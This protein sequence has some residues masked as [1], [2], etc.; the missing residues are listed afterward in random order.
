MIW[1][2]GSPITRMRPIGPCVADAQARVAAIALGRRAIGQV[3]PVRLAGVDHQ[4]AGVAPGL[5]Q[6]CIAGTMASSSETS[7]PRRLAEAAGLDEVALHVDEDQGGFRRA[8]IRRGKGWRLFACRTFDEPHE[9]TTACSPAPHVRPQHLPLGA[10][11][12]GVSNTTRPSLITT[13]R[14]ASSSSSSRSSLISSTAPPRARTCTMRLW[15]S[16]TAAKSSPNTGFAAISTLMSPA[17]SRASTARCTL[18]PDRLRI[19][20]PSPCVLTPY[21]AIHSRARLR[22]SGH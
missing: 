18:P 20:A 6:A 10:S 1:L 8:R 21:S 2:P 19:G 15:I 4:A 7:L 12:A 3:G 22:H 5:E 14:S 9:A 11:A 17:S 16:A 13:M